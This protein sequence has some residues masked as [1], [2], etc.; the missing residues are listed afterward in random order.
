MIRRGSSD[1]VARPSSP[2]WQRG[3]FPAIDLFSGCGGTSLG[4]QKAGFTVLSAVEINKAA[5]H[6]YRLNVGIGAITADIRTIKGRYLRRHAG[7][8][9]GECFLLTACPPCQGFSSQRRRQEAASDPRNNL[10][11]EVA[12]LT[13]EIGPA[14]LLLENVPGLAKGVGAD[15][16]SRMKNMLA[17]I[18]YVTV[19]EKIVEAYNYGLPQRRARLIYIARHE[20]M[21]SVDLAPETHCNPEK[22][23]LA[24]DGERLQPWRTVRDVFDT[25]RERLRPLT[26]GASDPDDPLHAAPAHAPDVLRRIMS[27][28]INGGGRRDLPES[29]VLGCH[30]NYTGHNDVYGRMWWDRPAPTLT[31]GCHKPSKGRFLHPDQ[32]RAISLREAALLQSFDIDTRFE[33]GSRDEIADQIGNAVPPDLIAALAQPF[34]QAYHEWVQQRVDRARPTYQPSDAK[35]CEIV[36]IARTAVVQETAAAR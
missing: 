34:K 7:L 15:L 11:L 21:P 14:Y 3:I 32:H 28:P 22:V 19:E 17:D 2:L 27:I 33:K 24:I 4:L 29:L 25:H 10:V 30:R 16:F 36:S 9:Y 5:A 1:R 8:R 23:P 6:N 18:G 13:G 12:R 20:S 31:G 35:N 26:A